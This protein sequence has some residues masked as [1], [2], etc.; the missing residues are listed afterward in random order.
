LLDN[1]PATCILHAKRCKALKSKGSASLFHPS[2]PLSS[3]IL[4]PIY[5]FIYFYKIVHEVQKYKVMQIN[6]N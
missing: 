2:S 3:P 4:H 1:A 5:L 6:E